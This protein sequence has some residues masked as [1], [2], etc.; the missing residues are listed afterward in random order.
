LEFLLEEAAHHVINGDDHITV[1]KTN[2]GKVR[3]K[4]LLRKP[5][6]LLGV[7][8]CERETARDFQVTE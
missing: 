6:K 3:W 8:H 4:R 5:K 2:E 7:L 1:R